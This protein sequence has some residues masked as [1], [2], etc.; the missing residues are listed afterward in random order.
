M[1]LESPSWGFRHMALRRS[2]IW[3]ANFLAFLPPAFML[4]FGSA[5]VW[6]FRGFR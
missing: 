6:A 2:T 4:A 3:H 1:A 5:L